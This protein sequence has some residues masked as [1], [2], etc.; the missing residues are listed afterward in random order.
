MESYS[1]H[2]ANVVSGR[3]SEDLINTPLL[4]A[5]YLTKNCNLEDNSSLDKYGSSRKPP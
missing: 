2:G 5:E 3:S 1:K 4:I